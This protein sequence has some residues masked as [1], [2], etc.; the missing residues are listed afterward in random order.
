MNIKTNDVIEGINYNEMW[1]HLEKESRFIDNVPWERHY[2]SIL[3]GLEKI[4]EEVIGAAMKLSAQR[5]GYESLGEDATTDLMWVLSL[6]F[7]KRTIDML[8]LK[9][10]NEA[11]D[12]KY[13]IAHQNLLSRYQK[14]IDG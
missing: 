3:S 1:I 13:R 6:L 9:S 2:S 4:K 11:K 14:I 10:T 8:T 5:S 12:E 7:V